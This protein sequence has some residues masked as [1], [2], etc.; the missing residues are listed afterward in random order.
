MY[1]TTGKRKTSVARIILQPGTG[2]IVVNG[3]PATQYFPRSASQYLLAQPFEITQTVGQY[4]VRVNVRGGGI[5]GQASAVRHGISKALL[6]VSP[7]LRA[8]LKS[9]GLLTR[10][11][12]EKERKKYGQK[13]ARKRFQYSKR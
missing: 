5:M 12:R 9:A 7:P 2:A 8:S 3:L 1:F 10:D 13:G 11:P 4:D 6:E